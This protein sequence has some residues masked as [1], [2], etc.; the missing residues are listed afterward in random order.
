MPIRSDVLNNFIRLHLFTR[1]RFNPLRF[2]GHMPCS[3]C[4][5]QRVGCVPRD[6]GRI[7]GW[8]AL[9]EGGIF[10]WWWRSI[11]CTMK[12]WCGACRLM[13]MVEAVIIIRIKEDIPQIWK[14]DM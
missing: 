5:Q 9:A 11:L 6:W 13:R 2:V 8:A 12:P 10:Q 14:K 1:F 4:L 7:Q 3:Y